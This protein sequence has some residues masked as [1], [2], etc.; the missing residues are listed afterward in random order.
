MKK[1]SE[2][3]GIVSESIIPPSSGKEGVGTTV[4]KCIQCGRERRV[5][6]NV[7]ETINM[8][9]TANLEVIMD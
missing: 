8:S 2:C 5:E 7:V 9:E 1:C 3:G 4:Y 6:K